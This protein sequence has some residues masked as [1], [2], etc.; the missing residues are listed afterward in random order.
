M[1]RS[2]I[3]A[4]G[5]AAASAASNSAP[6]LGGTWCVATPD[7]AR[8]DSCSFGRAH[9]TKW[10]RQPHRWNARS[11]EPVRTPAAELLASGHRKLTN[12]TDRG[13]AGDACAEA[14]DDDDDDDDDEDADVHALRRPRTHGQPA[15]SGFLRAAPRDWRMDTARGARPCRRHAAARMGHRH[16]RRAFC[17]T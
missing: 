12:I 6:R 8:I 10:T 17:Q 16:E 15:A 4:S 7:A 2:K 9:A 3:T 13:G 1:N 11:R 5:L 14:V